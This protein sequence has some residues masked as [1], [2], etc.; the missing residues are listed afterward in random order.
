MV[1]KILF[2]TGYPAAMLPAV[3]SLRVFQTL[4]VKEMKYMGLCLKIT[5]AVA[6][7]EK[8]QLL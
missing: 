6:P 5:W 2:Y 1:T 4:E 7:L 3:K 8:L